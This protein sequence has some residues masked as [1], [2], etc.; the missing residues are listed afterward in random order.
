MP[1]LFIFFA[2]LELQLGFFG[3]WDFW[4]TSDS[5]KIYDNVINQSSTMNVL[6]N[7]IKCNFREFDYIISLHVMR[8]M[9][10]VCLVYNFASLI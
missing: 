8:Y 7:Y 3:H 5:Y 9:Y 6:E 10:D 2:A 4:G 1:E